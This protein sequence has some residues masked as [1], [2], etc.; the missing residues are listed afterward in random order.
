MLENELRSFP[1]NLRTSSSDWRLN[2]TP[3]SASARM[4]FLAAG[5]LYRDGRRSRVQLNLNRLNDL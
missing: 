5:R 4:R 1:R 3:K 2:S